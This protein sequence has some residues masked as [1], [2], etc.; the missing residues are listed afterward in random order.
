[1]P[2][3]T[4]RW[5]AAMFLDNEEVIAAYRAAA[6]EEGD[7]QAVATAQR[8]IERAERNSSA[9]AMVLGTVN[10]PFAVAVSAPDLA[11]KIQDPSSAEHFDA[12]AFAFL[13]EVSPRLQAA[14]IE[15]MGVNK[16]KAAHVAEA[17]S[18]VAGYALTASPAPHHPEYE[19]GSE[20]A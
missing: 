11:A 6:F 13:W 2:V 19:R 18:A 14:F 5:D 15:A 17:L 9:V 12:W 3:E 10:A 1:M 8:D 16:A 20:N 7:V 4:T